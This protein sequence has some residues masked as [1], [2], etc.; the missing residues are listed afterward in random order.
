[1]K[2]KGFASKR[3]RWILAVIVV[4]AVSASA[5]YYFTNTTQASTPTETPMQ[6]ATAFRGSIILQ[7]SGTGTLT[8]ANEV[9]FG[10]GASGQITELNVMIA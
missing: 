9:S 7:A 10:F 6:T 2:K 3:T 1:M 5:V 8:S 4:L